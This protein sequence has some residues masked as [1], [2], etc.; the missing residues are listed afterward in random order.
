MVATG[1]KTK[2]LSLVNYTTKTIQFI[3]FIYY[4]TEN[5]IRLKLHLQKPK[6]LSFEDNL[7]SSIFINFDF[8]FEK[9]SF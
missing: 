5:L 2:H 8:L 9:L 3:S 7:S 6:Y 4:F 1:N